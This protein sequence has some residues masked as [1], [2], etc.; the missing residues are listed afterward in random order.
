MD[1]CP[2]KFCSANL[3]TQD[4]KVY[5][6]QEVNICTK[7]EVKMIRFFFDEIRWEMKSLFSLDFPNAPVQNQKAGNFESP[8]FVL[9]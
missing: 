8:A 4:N 9:V 1:Y 2:L 3:F 6:N 7:V 5:K